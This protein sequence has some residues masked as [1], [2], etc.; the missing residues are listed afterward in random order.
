MNFNFF[1]QRILM[2]CLAVLS[3]LTCLEVP[4]FI[5]A[6]VLILWIWKRLS[7]AEQIP[8]LS[9]RITTLLSLALLGFILFQYRTLFAEE[10]ASGLL[11]GLTALKIMD[12]SNSRDHYIV[13][14]L[15]FLLLTLKPL[16]GM[17]LYLFPIQMACMFGLWWSLTERKEDSGKKNLLP[18]FFTALPI[19]AFLFVLFPRVVLPWAAS[20]SRHGMAQMGFSNDLNPGQVAELASNSNLAFR[21][22]FFSQNL[23]DVRDLYWKGMILQRSEGLA[24]KARP[25]SLQKRA[26]VPADVETLRYQIILEPGTGSNLFT[27]DP[28]ISLRLSE[29]SATPLQ[30]FVWRLNG[31][32]GQSLIY[33]GQSVLNGV[34]NFSD[35][36][37]PGKEDLEI[38]DLPPESAAW[39]KN[40]KTRYTRIEDRKR[41]LKNLFSDPDLVYTLTP[42]TYKSRDLD[43]FIFHRKRGFC[44]HFSGGYATL[45]RALGIPARVVAGYQGAEFNPLGQFWK[46]TQRQSHAWVEI[47]EDNRWT[48]VDPT[49]WVQKS[50]FSRYQRQSLFEWFNQ[51]SDVY[52]A[53]NFRWTSF[54]IDFDQQTQ[55]SLIREWLP[56]GFLI[57]I[58]LLSLFFLVRLIGH[59][60]FHSS[61]KIHQEKLLSQLINEIYQ[62]EETR[63]NEKLS[64]LPPL[65]LLQQTGAFHKEYQLFF[66]QIQDS[67]EDFFYRPTTKSAGEKAKEVSL[68]QKQWKS[69]KKSF[70]QSFQQSLKTKKRNSN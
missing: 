14:L 44:E 52:E 17:D 12:Y 41:M 62:L 38:P 10:P 37:P 28:T 43:E 36:N 25:L 69:L 33:Q 13:I 53:L 67:Y 5:S 63:R 11:V 51:M 20:Q 49:T 64:S 32:S 22:Q 50:E 70:Q 56:R 27:L 59:W 65:S 6:F 15:G 48:R 7:D 2:I 47:W 19:G 45:A 39:V 68:L 66:A 18:V 16:F 57:T 23:P 24:W 34:S 60:L 29:G 61:E 3:V 31:S 9:R 55:K 21:V 46:V 26:A 40:V 58:L 54:L 35:S 42:G 8:V 4:I 30:G 1:D